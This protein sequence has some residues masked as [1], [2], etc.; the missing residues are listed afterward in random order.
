MQVS[1]LI[2]EKQKIREFDL[3]GFKWIDLFNPY[4]IDRKTLYEFV[5]YASK[6]YVGGGRYWILDAV[7]NHMNIYLY[8][9]NI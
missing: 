2:K 1:K 4:Y 9:I 7:I 5:V 8:V 3:K 6:K